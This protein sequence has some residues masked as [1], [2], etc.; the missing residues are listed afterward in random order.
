MATIILPKNLE[1]LLTL[2]EAIVLKHKTDGKKSPLIKTEILALENMVTQVQPKYLRLLKLQEEANQL[3]EEIQQVLGIHRHEK[4]ITVGT[5]RFIVAQSRD[6]LKGIHREDL[7][8]LRLWG[9]E[10]IVKETRKTKQ[11]ENAVTD[12]LS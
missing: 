9:Y 1:A 8:K 4:K 2:S 6:I 7:L 11:T 10:V 3:K 12:A 5:A